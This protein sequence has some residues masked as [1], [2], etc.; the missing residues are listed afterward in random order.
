MAEGL[1]NSP[2]SPLMAYRWADTDSA[3][4]LIMQPTLAHGRSARNATARVIEAAAL[5]LPQ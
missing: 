3:T 5:R 4:V 1:L 2:N